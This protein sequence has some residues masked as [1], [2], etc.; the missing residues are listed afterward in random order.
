ME[1]RQHRPDRVLVVGERAPRTIRDSDQ[2][3]NI[4]AFLDQRQ[5]GWVS[6]P[7]SGDFFVEMVSFYEG[8][9][10]LVSLRATPGFFESESCFRSATPKES[11]EF[12][13]L[14]RE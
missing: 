8:D 9:E 11:S 5:D 12:H 14:L 2:I 6:R 7:G 1:L 13:A 3:A 10:L 4:L